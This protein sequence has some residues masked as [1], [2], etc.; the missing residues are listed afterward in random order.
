MHLVPVLG[1][2]HGHVADRE[3]L[4]QAVEGCRCASATA[5]DHGGPQLPCHPPSGGEE[6]PVRERAD[7]PGRARVVHRRT[8]DDGVEL[9]ETGCQFV[10]LVVDDASA[11]LLTIA[12]IPAAGRVAPDVD[13]LGFY[14]S[15]AEFLCQFDQ[16]S[17]RAPAG[18]RAAVE[19]KRFHT[20]NERRNPIKIW[21]RTMERLWD[22]RPEGRGWGFT[23]PGAWRSTWTAARW[24]ASR[25]SSRG[26]RP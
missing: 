8:E 4:V 5:R 26:G 9:I 3:V 7:L 16:G 19:E 11:V 15:G 18:M 25:R 2:D 14:A 1:G 22:P 21:R 10:H 24:P 6:E 23:G 13:D 17:V 12:A 20:G